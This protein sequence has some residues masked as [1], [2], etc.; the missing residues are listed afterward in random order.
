[1]CC[2]FRSVEKVKKKQLL[3]SKNRRNRLRTVLTAFCIEKL[4]KKRFQTIPV[5]GSKQDPYPVP[6]YP[7]PV[8]PVLN[9]LTCTR[10]VPGTGSTENLVPLTCIHI[11]FRVL[12]IPDYA[13]FR[14]CDDER[15]TI[16]SSAGG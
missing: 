10:V 4:K 11:W 9:I 15:L 5:P 2:W 7:K 6:L 14:V 13:H 3:S 12:R 8:T 16:A 1:M